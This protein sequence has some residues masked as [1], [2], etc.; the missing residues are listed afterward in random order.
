MAG[1]SVV[2]VTG[3]SSGIGKAAAL[4]FASEKWRLSLN[5][6]NGEE[7]ENVAKEC[8]K[9]GATDV[10]LAFC[11]RR[12]PSLFLCLGDNYYWGFERRKCR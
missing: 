12:L 3:A 6:R 5:G 10:S 8:K 11:L 4:K 7:L 9:L 1:E 2:I